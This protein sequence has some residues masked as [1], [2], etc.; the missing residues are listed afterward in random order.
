MK[1]IIFEQV[2]KLTKKPTSQ[3]TLEARLTEDL[4][5]DSLDQVEL[6]MAVEDALGIEFPDEDLR[7]IRT[8]GDIVTTAS[9]FVK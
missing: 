8:V 6:A 4:D 5:L 9:K 2:A 3:I 1:E 7:L